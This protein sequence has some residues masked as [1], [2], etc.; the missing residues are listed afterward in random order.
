MNEMNGDLS[1]T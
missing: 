1:T